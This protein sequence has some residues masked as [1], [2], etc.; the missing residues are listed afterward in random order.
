MKHSRQRY[1]TN[2][3]ARFL[4]S[5]IKI[6]LIG[7]AI[8]PHS[9]LQSAP[10]SYPTCEPFISLRRL[11]GRANLSAHRGRRT[12]SCESQ[13]MHGSARKTKAANY[14]SVICEPTARRG[15]LRQFKNTLTSANPALK[16]PALSLTSLWMTL[17][18]GSL[19]PSSCGDLTDLYAP[20][21]TCFWRLKNLDPWAPSSSA[22]IVSAVAQLERDLIRERVRDSDRCDFRH[23]GGFR[24]TLF[25]L[26]SKVG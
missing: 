4:R 21:S 19:T 16:T 23:F 9:A 14:N 26:S 11:N 3:P 24:T 5:P 8:F 13:F 6:L 7:K 25:V 10:Q 22:T 20:R 18:S 2:P 1:L 15:D 17:G 12:D